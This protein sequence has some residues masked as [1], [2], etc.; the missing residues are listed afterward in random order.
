MSPVTEVMSQQK[1]AF[2]NVE[3]CDKCN[4]EYV[5]R[6][7]GGIVRCCG[8]AGIWECEWLAT[9]TYIKQTLQESL[10]IILSTELKRYLFASFS[11]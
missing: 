6:C 7:D 5:R 1:H 11:F 8:T 2:S 9:D 10:I 4:N 3:L